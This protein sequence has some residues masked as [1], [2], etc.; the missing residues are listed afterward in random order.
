[1][2]TRTTLVMARVH[3][4]LH[5]KP[6][7]LAAADAAVLAV[8]YLVDD[9]LQR[10]SGRNTEDV[11]GIVGRPRDLGTVTGAVRPQGTPRIERGP[12]VR[13]VSPINGIGSLLP[14][15]CALPDD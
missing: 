9:F 6:M 10:S 8:A 3:S 7:R 4:E 15:R 13:K 1:M 5:H 11:G 14:C 2:T 12:A